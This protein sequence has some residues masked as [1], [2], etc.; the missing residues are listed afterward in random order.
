MVQDEASITA[1]SWADE[2][3]HRIQ[4]AST[5]DE[6]LGRSRQEPP[7]AL[8]ESAVAAFETRHGVTLPADYRAF[9]TR[10]ANGDPGPD[11]GLGPLRYRPFLAPPAVVATVRTADGE[12]H[13]AETGPR[14]LPSRT[15]ELAE[16]FRL[17]SAWDPCCD[18]LPDEIMRANLYDGVLEIGEIGCGYFYLLVVSGA[19]RGE[20]WVDYTAGDG[21]L[22]KVA[23]SFADWFDAWLNASTLATVRDVVAHALATAEWSPHPTVLAQLDALER[24]ARAEDAGPLLLGDLARAYVYAGRDQDAR[25]LLTELSEASPDRAAIEEL[26]YRTELGQIADAASEELGAWVTH[27]SRVVREAILERD[28][29]PREH[30]GPLLLADEA[31]RPAVVA[32]PQC[33]G[34]LLAELVGSLSSP[35]PADTDGYLLVDRIARHPALALSTGE[36]LLR[37]SEG[38]D[39]G[40]GS[41]AR[42]ALA[43]RDE[44]WAERLARDVAPWV[45]HAVAANEASP[46]ATLRN[47]AGDLHWGVWLGLAGNPATPGDVLASLCSRAWDVPRVMQALARNPATPARTLWTMFYRLDREYT[48]EIT[49]NPALPPEIMLAMAT[50]LEGHTML[51]MLEREHVPSEVLDALAAHWSEEVREDARAMILSSAGETT[52]EEDWDED[53]WDEDDDLADL[54]LG[55]TWEDLPPNAGVAETLAAHAGVYHPSYPAGLLALELARAD[56]AQRPTEAMAVAHSPWCDERVFARLAEHPYDYTRRAIAEHP[57]ATEV[58]LTQIAGDAS[59]LVRAGVAERPGLPAA[60]VSALM[61]DA[62]DTVVACLARSAELPRAW[63]L[64]R[65]TH[66][67][68]YVRRSALMNPNLAPEDIAAFVEMQPEQLWDALSA[69]SAPAELVARASTHDDP[70]IRHRALWRQEG[71]AFRASAQS[72]SE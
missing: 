52:A 10:I 18:D 7:P 66:P 49:R 61:E 30:L 1:A 17:D 38:D 33:D 45:R 58:T 34:A 51:D 19:G 43:A 53:E 37:W 70:S 25:Q 48:F 22:M 68:A 63:L 46:E 2:V 5:L 64:E 47:L 67:E 59:P 41:V 39:L 42:R 44:R 35:D 62:E 65:L 36:A 23:D 20:V 15:S 54:G 8:D 69:P 29:L 13:N 40:P 32:H 3:E 57:S 6:L 27:P 56:E 72:G 24:A 16:P 26:V 71:D 55:T 28:D 14:H 11:L 60:L 9:L 4:I 21:Q 50:R 31:L 12:E